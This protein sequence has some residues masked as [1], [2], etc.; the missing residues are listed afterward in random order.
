MF[1]SVTELVKQIPNQLVKI[2]EHIKSYPQNFIYFSVI[3]FITSFILS[4]VILFNGFSGFRD[5]FADYT[6]TISSVFWWL[7]GMAVIFFLVT[8][9]SSSYFRKTNIPGKYNGTLINEADRVYSMYTHDSDNSFPYKIITIMLF[10]I[11]TMMYIFYTGEQGDDGPSYTTFTF[12]TA[13]FIFVGTL[14]VS[15]IYLKK[16][17]KDNWLFVKLKMFVIYLSCHL[18]DFFEYIYT[19]YKITPR[20]TFIVLGIQI[21][22]FIVYFGAPNFRSIYNKLIL[23]DGH[24]IVT[25]RLYLDSEVSMSVGDT[26]FQLRPV[27]SENNKVSYNYAISSWIYLMDSRGSNRFKTIIN[28]ANK[29]RVEYNDKTHVLRVSCDIW[30]KDG[31]GQTTT[32][33]YSTSDIPLQKWNHIVFNFTGGI[34][35]IFINSKLV[36]STKGVLP[37]DY[38]GDEVLRIG[39]NQGV[40]GEITDV[41]YFGHEISNTSIQNIYET[42]KDKEERQSCDSVI[43]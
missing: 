18:V 29:P 20:V 16:I 22:A 11:F 31:T 7:F 25:E 37:G 1:E 3:C 32:E 5:M 10:A 40:Q 14:V 28:Y 43:V 4:L 38:D 13:M 42:K 30:D 26:S 41:T 36:C 17:L 12:F 27:T 34:L 21:I 8:I 2:M 23:H 33:L 35:D 39:D 19:E 24:E 15:A 9:G 6:K